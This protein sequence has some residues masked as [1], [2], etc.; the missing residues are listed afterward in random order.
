[1]RMSSSASFLRM[2]DRLCETCQN[3]GEGRNPSPSR[4]RIRNGS[5]FR[6]AEARIRDS[7]PGAEE[8]NEALHMAPSYPAES[9]LARVGTFQLLLVGHDGPTREMGKRCR[10]LDRRPLYKC[11][12]DAPRVARIKRCQHCCRWLY[13]LESTKRAYCSERCRTDAAAFTSLAGM[14]TVS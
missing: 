8:R 4:K 13:A 3:G 11:R 10:S 12:K 7:G 5:L 6:T 1:M 9:G 2:G 14:A